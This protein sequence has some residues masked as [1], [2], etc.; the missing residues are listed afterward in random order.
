MNGIFDILN[1]RTLLNTNY[2]FNVS[3]GVKPHPA[4]RHK[5]GEDAFF[6]Y[7]NISC[8]AIGVADGVGGWA[9]QGVDPGIYSRQLLGNVYDYINRWDGYNPEIVL[10]DALYHAKNNTK[11]LGSSTATI[12]L[13]KDGHLHTANLGDSGFLII[14]NRH[15]IFKSLPQQHSF[16]FPYQLQYNGGDNIEDIDQ[17]KIPIQID[18]III[19]GTDGLFDNLYPEQILDLINR[20]SNLNNLSVNLV[21][22]AFNLS[23]NNNWISP[24]S[25]EAKKNNINNMKGGK[26]DDITIIVAQVTDKE[27]ELNNR[28]IYKPM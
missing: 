18:D 2:G 24:F 21:H 3:V 23:K 4:K 13:L 15:I 25:F 1:N 14:R 9:E 5:G 12:L 19:V 6:L 28:H 20:N 7:N 10:K 27:Q 26:M 16:N 22:S 11:V 17:K 8:S